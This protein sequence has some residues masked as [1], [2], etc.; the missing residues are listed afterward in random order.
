MAN[1][2]IQ[3]EI[4]EYKKKGDINCEHA[5]QKD[6]GFQS[7]KERDIWSPNMIPLLIDSYICANNKRESDM[8]LY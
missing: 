4:Y 6:L 2:L 1:R 3:V 8:D 7:K 5:N